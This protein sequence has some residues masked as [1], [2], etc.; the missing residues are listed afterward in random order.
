MRALPAIIAI[1]VVIVAA[2]FVADHPGTVDIT[3]GRWVIGTSLGVA[4][5]SVAGAALVLALLW[6][7]ARMLMRG[8]GTWSRARRERRRRD[9]Y[10]ALTQGMVAVAAGDAEEAQKLARKADTLLAEPP[11]TLL[12]SA[13]AA[14]LNG[15]EG[16][17]RRYFHAMLERAETEFLGLRGLVMQALRAGDEAAA[18]GLVERAKALRPR[19]PWVMS[20]LLELQARAGRWRDAEATLIEA[21]KRK[22]L[23]AATSRHRHAVLLLQD[24]KAAEEAGR[25]SDAMRLAGKAHAIEPS[26]APVAARY[27]RML[28]ARGQMRRARRALEAAWRAA[29]HPDIAAAYR[30]IHADEPVLERMKRMERLAAFAAEHVESRIAL[31]TSALEAKLWGEARRHLGAA[32]PE[33]EE[34][35][36]PRV[37][38]LMAEIEMA[39]HED[40]AAARTWLARAAAA[41]VPDAAWV[42]EAC[43]GESATWTPL[44]GQC[45]SFATLSWRGPER[46]TEPRPLI[47]RGAYAA[48]LALP[49][50]RP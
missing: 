48:S 46:A 31:A 5:L 6:M 27:G 39:E 42:C 44:C 49:S 20:H 24:S 32:L 11:L 1:I 45:R 10:R 50:P 18:I 34:R 25:A 8:P 43:G 13:Q 15:D 9:G 36:P 40:H 29:P 37:S 19:T 23:S 21:T 4:A 30:A 38:R 3:Y 41:S 12:L 17:A 35:A 7:V 26:F 16:A 22:V 28:G 33:G 2:V 47:D 14:Q